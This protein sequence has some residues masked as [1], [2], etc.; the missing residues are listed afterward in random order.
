MTTKVKIE[1]VQEHMPVVVEVAGREVAVL[2]EAGESHED[3]VHSSQ[4]IVVRELT[5]DELSSLPTD[6]P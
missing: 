4:Q 3:Y 1:L 6:A 5:P 2:L